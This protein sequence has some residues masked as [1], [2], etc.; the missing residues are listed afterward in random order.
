MAYAVDGDG[1]VVDGGT[2]EP[3]SWLDDVE[4]ELKAERRQADFERDRVEIEEGYTGL[5]QEVKAE[6]RQADFER[7]RP[8]ATANDPSV[9]ATPAEECRVPTR[10]FSD[11]PCNDDGYRDASYC[12]LRRYELSV[13]PLILPCCYVC[14]AYSEPDNDC[15]CCGE[16]SCDDCME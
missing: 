11:F 1:H 8:A 15:S 4:I 6:L 12:C 14:E 10:C 13:L 7:R 9:S 2:G 16:D 3:F 5:V